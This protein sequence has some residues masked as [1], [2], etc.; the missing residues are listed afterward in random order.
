MKIY[1]KTGDTGETSLVG[2]TR[3]SKSNAQI[4]AYGTVDELN[5]SL[6]VIAS[7]DSHYTDFIKSIQH[8]LFNIG[9]V[10]AAEGD[11]EFELPDIELAD[12]TVLENEIDRLNTSLP[13]L[14][15]FI[16][17]GG[18]ILSAHTHVSRC[19]CRRA[20][21]RVVILGDTKYN[22]HIKYLNRLSDYLFILSREF[23]RLEGK[24]EVLWQKD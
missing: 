2:G 9:S 17:P 23:L 5:S 14:K 4:E 8:K 15:N 7:L 21:R 22:T 10:L 6:G 18:S 3:V 13:R 12:I 16:L 11:L 1:T 19:I 24:E 20:E